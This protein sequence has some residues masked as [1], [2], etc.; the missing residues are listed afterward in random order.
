MTLKTF[1][2]DPQHATQA[3]IESFELVGNADSVNNPSFDVSSLNFLWMT[4]VKR[5]GFEVSATTSPG[6]SRSPGS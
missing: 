2:S 6:R 4:R 1:L 5:P 3:D